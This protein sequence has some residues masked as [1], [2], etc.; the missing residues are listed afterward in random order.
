MSVTRI[1]F[2]SL[3]NYFYQNKVLEVGTSKMCWILTV[4]QN[5]DVRESQT[6]DTKQV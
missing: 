5:K 4:R 3:G 2:Q 6:L 1:F